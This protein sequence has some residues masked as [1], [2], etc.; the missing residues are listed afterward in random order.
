MELVTTV[1]I[2]E[3]IFD[4]LSVYFNI[5]NQYK[6]NTIYAAVCGIGYNNLIN[7]IIRMGFL[8]INLEIYG[9]SDQDI[10]IYKQIKDEFR[11]FIC[12]ATLYTNTLAK[13]FGNINDGIK[14]KKAIL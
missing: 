1:V 5:K 4:L 3:G 9:D 12:K 10:R 6:E 7:E 14:I 11:D 13:D 8:Q 2:T